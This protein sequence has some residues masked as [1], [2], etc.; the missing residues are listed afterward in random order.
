MKK[1]IFVIILM[2]SCHILFAQNQQPYWGSQF[3]QII[4]TGDTARIL[5][6]RN[7]NLWRLK[8]TIPAAN[9]LK[10]DNGQIVAFAAGNATE[11]YYC[12]VRIFNDKPILIVIKTKDGFTEFVYFE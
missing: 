8:L 3:T 5:I 2:I 4:I 1:I 10:N 6:D 9:V 11:N 7:D 12:I